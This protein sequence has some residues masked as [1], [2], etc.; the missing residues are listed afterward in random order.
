MRPGY[1]VVFALAG[2]AG[3]PTAPQSASPALSADSLQ[4]LAL[5]QVRPLFAQ[6]AT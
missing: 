4:R 2:C 5:H 3:A 6:R 1:L